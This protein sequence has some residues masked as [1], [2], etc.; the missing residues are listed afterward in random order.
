[1]WAE[2]AVVAGR[3]RPCQDLQAAGTLVVEADRIA[4]PGS[5]EEKQAEQGP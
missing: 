4:A 1:V 2:A 5:V 3:F